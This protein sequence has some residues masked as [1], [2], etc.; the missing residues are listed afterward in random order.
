MQ[1]KKDAKKAYI[2]IIIINRMVLTGGVGCWCGEEG[3]LPPG[4]SR[5]KENAQNRVK[6][7][8]KWPKESSKII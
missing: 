4:D 5:G 3:G 1:I 6:K 2:S 7:D 8:Q